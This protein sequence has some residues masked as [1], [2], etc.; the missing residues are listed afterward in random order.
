MDN[1][2]IALFRKIGLEKTNNFNYSESTN[3]FIGNGYTSLAGN[4][5]L[6]EIRLIE[7]LL[8]KEDVGQGYARTF[9]NGIRIFNLKTKELLCEKSYHCQFYSQYFIKLEVRTML[10]D[11]LI[12]AAQKDG[13]LLNESEISEQID[14]LVNTAFSTDQRQM[15]LQQSRK[16]LNS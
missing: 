13:I 12:S 10:N 11:L 16:Y 5:Y 7:G 14:K 8:V 9:I 6:N 3:A 1:M 4:T 2:G 15:L